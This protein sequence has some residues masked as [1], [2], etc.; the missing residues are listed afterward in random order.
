MCKGGNYMRITDLLNRRSIDLNGTPKTKN[1][2][3]DQ[4]I[5]LMAKSGTLRDVDAYRAEVY[6]REEEST[7]ATVS[8]SLTANATRS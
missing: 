3:L 4:M 6:R 8:R 5:A 2:A 7:T 1:E